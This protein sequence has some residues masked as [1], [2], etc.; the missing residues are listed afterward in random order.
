MKAY[1]LYIGA[2]NETGK[3]ELDKLRATLDKWYK[4]YTIVHAVGAWEGQREPSVIVTI[5][6]SHGYTVLV[7]RMQELKRE[8]KQE[9]IG[10]QEAPELRFV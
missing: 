9:A 3:L 4:G 1:N 8:L 10:V 5:Q 2:N 7:A 6:P